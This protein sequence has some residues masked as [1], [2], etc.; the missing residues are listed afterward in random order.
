MDR[1]ERIESVKKSKL[2]RPWDALLIGL[3]VVFALAFLFLLPQGNGDIV[4]IAVDGKVL[5]RL[6]LHEDRHIEIAAGEGRNTVVISGGKVHIID[7]DC[8]DRL[9]EHGEIHVGGQSI[10]CLPHALVVRIVTDQLDGV[11]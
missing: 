8:P 5:H 9:C 1:K 3:A 7:A 2:L 4:E 10:V 6:P 11:V